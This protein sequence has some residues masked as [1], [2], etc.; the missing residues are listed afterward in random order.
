MKKA[1][2]IIIVLPFFATAQNSTKAKPA[3]TVKKT[4][5]AE[6]KP[7]EGF[8]ING[9]VTG[10][11]DGTGVALLNGQTGAPQFETTISKNKFTFQGKITT[12]DFLFLSFNKQGPYIPLFL[13][14]SA[15]KIQGTKSKELV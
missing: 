12:P 2:F 11:T 9:D 5:V 4:A 1:L 13:D 10:Y 3:N 6:V 7:V 8:I 14:N 15:V